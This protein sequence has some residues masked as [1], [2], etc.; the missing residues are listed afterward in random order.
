MSFLS[1]SG[2]PAN[3]VS[4]IS[5][6]WF[7]SDEVLETAALCIASQ[8]PLT[9][10]PAPAQPLRP[11]QKCSQ[12]LSTFSHIILPSTG[13]CFWDISSSHTFYTFSVFTSS[14]SG[15]RETV[16]AVVE[17]ALILLWIQLLSPY[18]GNALPADLT[19]HFHRRQAAFQ[20]I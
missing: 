13:I 10:L 1:S 17:A 20:K 3:A 2:N 5:W 9:S 6:W 8:L 14:L 16:S 15:T 11:S 7:S 19:A 12:R 4:V 18:C